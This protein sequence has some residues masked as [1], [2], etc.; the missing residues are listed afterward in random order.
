MRL[1]EFR[2]DDELGKDEP[3]EENP[4][5]KE[6]EDALSALHKEFLRVDTLLRNLKEEK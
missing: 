2:E 3:E 5:K 6:L 4:S 1:R